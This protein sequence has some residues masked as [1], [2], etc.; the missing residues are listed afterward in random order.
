MTRTDVVVVGAG[1]AGL[2]CAKRLAAAGADVVVLEARDRVGGRTLNHTLACGG[3]V[4][5]GGQWVG[6]HQV[7]V[8]SLL[9]ELGLETFPTYD[10]GDNM[11]EHA[12]ALRRYAGSTPSL[13]PLILADIGVAMWRLDR[14]ARTVPLDAPWSAAKASAWDG[15]TV[16]A[17]LS[18]QVASAAAKEYFRLLC[19]AV[20]AADPEDV[21][22]LHFLF[23]VHS[24][25][26]IERLISTDGGAQQMRIVGGSQQISSRLAADLDA[27]VL[28]GTRV[29]GIVRHL[30]GGVTVR[31]DN[32][33][34]PADAVV[35]A[36]PPPLAGRLHY[37]PALPADRDQLT[38]RTP[39]GSVVK[40]M[41]AYSSPFWRDAG[42]SGQVTSTAG[43]VK[44]VFDNSPHDSPSGVLVAFLEGRQ[45]RMISGAS[46]PERRTVV[47]DCLIRFF[48][49]QAGEPT[50]YVDLVWADEPYTRGC[51]GAFLPPNTWT[52][53]GQ[54][55]RRPIG[56]IHWASSETALQW[57]GYMDGAVSSGQRAAEQVLASLPSR[58][59][60]NESTSLWTKDTP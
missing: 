22:L 25:G 49:D 36:L 17:W 12:G 60:P 28:L 8:L 23:Y 46:P 32:G 27:R 52:S 19:E 37:E 24:A 33:D 48:G 5:L 10:I 26:G 56:D 7:A 9:D 34:W 42:L 39:Q 41:A 3:T 2:V 38:Q 43:P 11:F 18:R 45:A 54:A 20:W 15:Q 29:H 51:Y 35:V 14:M 1:I 53:F 40:C 50:E 47:L 6:P 13:T 30:A 58:P 44:V 21:S 31:A 57:S 55:M 59:Q 4:E 16:A